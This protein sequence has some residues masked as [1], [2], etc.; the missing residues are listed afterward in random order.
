MKNMMDETLTASESRGGTG[1]VIP[2]PPQ[3][4]SQVNN[5]RRIQ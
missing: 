2:P 4:A 3:R 1:H 5:F